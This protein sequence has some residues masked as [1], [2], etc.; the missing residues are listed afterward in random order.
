MNIVILGAGEV[1]SSVAESLVSEDNEITIVD[2]EP[3]RLARLQDRLDLRTVA[4][5]AALPS[6]LERA[7]VDDADLLIAVT[8]SDETNLCACRT[9]ATL[10]KTPT[11][12]ARLC[13]ADYARH[14]QLL[15]AKN[16]AVD[17]SICPEQVVTDYIV[18]LIEFPEAL[19]V[20]EFADGLVS[21]V[22]V[23][24]F[25]GGP[26]V[27]HPVSDLRRHLPGLDAR[28]AAIYRRDQPIA[29][30]GGTVIEAGDE[31]FYLA[32]TR[33]IRKVTTELRRLAWTLTAAIA[34]VPL[35]LHEPLAV[36]EP[37]GFTDAFFET[38]SALTT[39]GATVMFGLDSLAP[40][41]NLWRHTLQWLGGMG[42]IVLAVA[43]LPLLGVGGMQLLR[44]EVPGPIK[45]TKLTARIGDTAAILW[46]VCLGITIACILALRIAGMGWFD[47]V[48]HAFATLSLGGSRPGMQASA[49]SIRR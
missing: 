39:T 2:S 41:I 29:P 6:V 25:E 24:A 33:D 30:E 19:Q 17:L 22:A 43:I 47:A 49:P 9:A 14:P 8:Q 37:Q 45:D 46:T 15:D 32:A 23:R 16:F 35:M 3:A 11:R 42:I 13:S 5:N 21:L 26:L 34:T 1:G 28:I 4:G 44:A 40:S 27:G 48:C 12:I 31:V 7:G 36:D 18:K 20:L 10:F 38:M